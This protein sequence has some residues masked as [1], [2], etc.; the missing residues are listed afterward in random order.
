VRIGSKPGGR[1]RA[2]LIGFKPG[3][4]ARQKSQGG[5]SAAVPSRLRSADAQSTAKSSE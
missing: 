5:L 1:S 3:G 4:H 2:A